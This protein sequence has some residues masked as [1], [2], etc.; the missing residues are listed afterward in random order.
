[1]DQRIIYEMEYLEYVVASVI[2]GIFSG[3][4]WMVRRLLTNEKQIE[5]LHSEIK[6]RDIRRQEDREIMYEIKNDLKEVK[7]DVIELY[8]TQPDK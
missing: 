5:L 4:T 2:A 3:I 6:D 1:M 8:K 7:R